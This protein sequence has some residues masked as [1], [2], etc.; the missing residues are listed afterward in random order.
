MLESLKKISLLTKF[1]YLLALVIFIAWVV[2]AIMNYQNKSNN[3]E[4]SMQ[5]IKQAS[6]KYAITT[7]NQKFTSALF[8]KETLQL[9]SKVT[10][11]DLGQQRYTIHINMKKEDIKKFKSFIETLSLRYLV[12]I[13]N[14]IDFQAKEDDVQV[15]MTVK[16]L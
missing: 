7:K 2:P 14:A 6:S 8:T 10:V 1:I 5:E 11:K 3:Y 15:T 9:F 12:E 16:A 13:E 4:K